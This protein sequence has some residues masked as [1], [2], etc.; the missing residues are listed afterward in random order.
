VPDKTISVARD[1]SPSPAGRYYSDGPFS[2]EKFR[3]EFLIPSL[4]EIADGDRLIV[5]LDGADGMGSSFLEEAFGGLKRKGFSAKTIKKF[6]SIKSSR[7]IYIR[8]IW[9][10][11]NG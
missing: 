6:I 7:Q 11:V 4:K 1:F 2:G 3:E 10:Y 9:D 5:D 8:K